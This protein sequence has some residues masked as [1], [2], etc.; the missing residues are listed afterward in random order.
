MEKI[1]TPNEVLC[2]RCLW[3]NLLN[4]PFLA[5]KTWLTPIGQ[6]QLLATTKCSLQEFEIV[7]TGDTMGSVKLFPT[8]C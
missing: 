5:F 1:F 8:P 4:E 3:L 2:S 7:E 6:S